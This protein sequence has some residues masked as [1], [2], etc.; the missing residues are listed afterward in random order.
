MI[1]KIPVGR[2]ITDNYQHGVA[3]NLIAAVDPESGIA[4]QP[5]LGIGLDCHVVERH[6]DTNAMLGGFALP[7]W[8]VLKEVVLRGTRAF[9]GLRWQ[10]WDIAFARDGPTALEVNL[11]AGGGTDIAQVSHGK[12]LLDDTLSRLVRDS[13]P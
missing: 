1:W 6:P 13:P 9:P 8:D 10:H 4:A 5:V 7:Q 3:G 2:N 11:Y 12:G